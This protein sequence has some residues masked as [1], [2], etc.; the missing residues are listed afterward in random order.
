MGEKESGVNPAGSLLFMFSMESFIVFGIYA[1]WFPGDAM[2]FGGVIYIFCGLT[3]FAG[4]FIYAGQGDT[5]GYNCWIS[6]GFIFGFLMGAGNICGALATTVGINVPYMMYSVP[7]IILGISDTIASIPYLKGDS[8]PWLTWF[9]AHTWC[10]TSGLEYFFPIKI[11]FN[12]NLVLSFI[13][14]CGTAYMM[15]NEFMI[16]TGGKGLP[17]GKPLV[18]N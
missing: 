6:Y 7:L 13:V 5:Y 10:V 15:T 8:V 18:R 3:Y 14:G 12:V 17:M 2:L 11:W 9:M 16:S 4:A 1:G